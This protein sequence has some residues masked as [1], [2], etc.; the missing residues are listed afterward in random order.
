MVMKG[1]EPSGDF[2]RGRRVENCL[3]ISLSDSNACIF[4]K[5]PVADVGESLNVLPLVNAGAVLSSEF[6]EELIG[7]VDVSSLQDY[8]V[9]I[10]GDRLETEDFLI[11]YSV[12]VTPPVDP[13]DVARNSDGTWKY[14]FNEEPNF[15]LLNTHVFFWLNYLAQSIK[16]VTGTFYGEGKEIKVVPLYFFHNS[17]D[18]I[19]LYRN[20]AWTG[21]DFNLMLFGLSDS[22]G[23]DEN[24]ESVHIPLAFD[25]GIAAHE[26]GHAI[27]DYASPN[28]IGL[29]DDL[30][31]ICGS[32]SNGYC[33]IDLKGGPLSIHEGVGD[34]V[35]SISLS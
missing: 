5:N 14:T 20:A 34:V 17:G 1:M 23:V 8:A 22:M 28:L 35:T 16:N 18:E 9:S 6:E 4:G 26:A 21:T 32:E 27:L 3:D 24:G 2:I 11:D 19:S 10:P 15:N 7:L 25:S 12:F 31:E 33:A 30:E 13:S 29:N